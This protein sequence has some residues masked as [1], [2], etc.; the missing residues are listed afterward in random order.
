MS[1]DVEG[2]EI[3]TAEATCAIDNL[4]PA[5]F[6]VGG[7]SLVNAPGM[8]LFSSGELAPGNHTAL[9]TYLGNGSTVPLTLSYIVLNALPNFSSSSSTT[10]HKK[11]V[12]NGVM[13]LVLFSLLLNIWQSP[14]L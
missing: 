10:I 6:P 9:I 2:V 14:M 13:V 7:S 3:L 4:T 5:P 11:P 12:I 1:L 8:L